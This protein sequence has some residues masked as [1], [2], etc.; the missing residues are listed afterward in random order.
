MLGELRKANLQ[1]LPKYKPH[2]SLFGR[3]MSDVGQTG[4]QLGQGAVGFGIGM[5]VQIWHGVRD[6]VE[7]P[8]HAG[9]GIT[10]AAQLRPGPAQKV[11]PKQM[12]GLPTILPRTTADA[13]AQAHIVKQIYEDPE[14]NIG[15]ALVL[16]AS[17][18]LPAIGKGA[19]FVRGFRE[20]RGAE[21]GVTVVPAPDMPNYPSG[22]NK[23]IMP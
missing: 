8:T 16:G 14:H 1:G 6:V 22:E 10:K 15:N 18:G 3:I 5:P 19:E 4:A 20:A 12:K 2:Q 13:L 11:T 17:L 21:P 9:K 23:L 7:I